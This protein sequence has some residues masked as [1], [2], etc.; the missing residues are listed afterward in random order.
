M[1]GSK[2]EIRAVLL[3]FGG[4]IVEELPDDMDSVLLELFAAKGLSLDK[5]STKR[6]DFS[7]AYWAR[8]YS[9]LS[10]GSRWTPAIRTDCNLAL[11]DHYGL[12]GDKERVAREIAERDAWFNLRATFPDVLPTLKALGKMGLM[13]GV[14]S[15]SLHTSEELR[16]EL[17]A[18]GLGSHF[19]LVLTSESAGIDKPDPRLYLDALSHLGVKPDQACHVGDNI[20][21][22]VRAASEAGLLGILIDRKAI[23]GTPQGIMTIRALTELPAL[24]RAR[25]QR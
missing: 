15:Q 9:A 18:R 12:S 20:E 19:D 2:T 22:D 6:D 1:S 11:M 16:E 25:N 24:I 7:R 14:V 4:T 10:R 23:T 5:R 8:R 17:R 21:K 13:L 3:D